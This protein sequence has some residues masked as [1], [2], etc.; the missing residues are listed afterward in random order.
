MGLDDFLSEDFEAA[1]P[2]ELPP[3]EDASSS[4]GF[5]EDDLFDLRTLEEIDAQAGE[6]E[7][8][9]NPAGGAAAAPEAAL[10]E[11]PH[12][13]S[14]TKGAPTVVAGAPVAAAPEPGDEAFDLDEDLFD[15][16]SP[17]DE[18]LDGLLSLGNDLAEILKE[19]G[20][21]PN[22][23]EL[24]ELAEAT[25]FDVDALEREAA[26]QD[27]REGGSTG[28]E[29]G[30]G[31]VAYAS[32]ARASVTVLDPRLLRPRTSWPAI[33]AVIAANFILLFFAWSASSS[34][35][36]HLSEVRQELR[37]RAAL[38]AAAAREAVVRA[39]ETA[40]D[41]LDEP[42]AEDTPGE[43]EPR[44]R[45]IT[46]PRL[47]AAESMALYVAEREIADERFAD[48]RRRLYRLLAAADALEPETRETIETRALFLVADTYA[49]Q[50]ALGEGR[51]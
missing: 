48:A 13:P 33:A 26:L 46:L 43:P 14:A 32:D 19:V 37:Q 10:S 38:D 27:E 4:D 41:P 3:E 42:D 18:H 28:A 20:P 30:R 24:E 1:E 44:E 11:P 22:P 39:P 15:F 8:G 45:P 12:T 5:E 31:G 16:G 36:A 51:P 7:A 50:A 34:L 29:A 17:G 2:L 21:A 9:D 6:A 40:A 49:R 47:P 35:H 23:Q 25:A